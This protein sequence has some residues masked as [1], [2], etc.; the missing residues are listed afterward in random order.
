MSRLTKVF[1]FVFLMLT[2]AISASATD[3][4]FNL[5][6]LLRANSYPSTV[7]Y[8]L[9]TGMT[10]SNLQSVTLHVQGTA[11]YALSDGTLP[12]YTVGFRYGYPF[13]GYP[14][15]GGF[16]HHWGYVGQS[17]FDLSHTWK[18]GA[19]SS[20]NL[21]L[22]ELCKGIIMYSYYI[23]EDDGSMDGS[24]WINANVATITLSGTAVPEPS[25]LVAL[26]SSFLG[27]GFIYCRRK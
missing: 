16:L 12:S 18:K 15:A 25:S 26:M 6:E 7:E 24:G 19:D 17:T 3:Y 5:A 21:I 27:V 10:F 2:A 20:V 8:Q 14:D 22:S 11:Y 4:T 9:N 13:N 23:V 1:L